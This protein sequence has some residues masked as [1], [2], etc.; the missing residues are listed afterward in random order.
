MNT[1]AI[2]IPYRDNADI[3]SMKGHATFGYVCHQGLTLLGG[4]LSRV[5]FLQPGSIPLVSDVEIKVM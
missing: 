4:S 3:L 2:Y 1:V 5:V